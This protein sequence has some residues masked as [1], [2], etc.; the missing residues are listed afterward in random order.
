[1]KLKTTLVL[2]LI[3]TTN[4]VNGQFA[5][6]VGEVGTSAISKDSSII[7]DWASEVIDFQRGLE[8][9]SVPEGLLATFG[10]STEALGVAEGT[11]GDVVSLGD[12]GS[13]VL[14]F[15]YSLRNDEGYDFLV[16]EN[17]FSDNYL[18]FAHVEVSSDGERF[19][20][21][22]S[23]SNIQI[24]T[25]TGSFGSSD[26]SLVHNLAGKYRQG[27]GTPFDLNDIVDSTGIDLN[28]VNFVRIVDVVGS[29]D[30][31]YGTRDSEGNLIN[32]PF[33]TDFESGGFDLDAVGVIHDN[34][35]F[36]N[37]HEVQK[38]SINIYPNPTT[39]SL[40]IDLNQGE[41][42]SVQILDELGR[43]LFSGNQSTIDLNDLDIAHGSYI[44]VISDKEGNSR[45]SRFL[46][47]S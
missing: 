31:L 27:Y 30:P 44:I 1:M 37:L 28:D 46:F 8:D 4:L 25:Q 2:T 29:V 22:P 34:N 15:P 13:I 40:F 10:D 39:G 47:T 24:D 12:N 36:A 5:P 42:Q 41:I 20:R 45:M 43:I 17:S 7:V 33:K 26:A 11:S 19:I 38:N 23:I 21:I 3:I 14:S 35:P 16:F 18:E 9:I 32:D 6:P